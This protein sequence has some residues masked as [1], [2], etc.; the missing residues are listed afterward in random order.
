VDRQTNP[1]SN[2]PQPPSPPEEE[3]VADDKQSNNTC[4]NE[5]VSHQEGSTTIEFLAADNDLKIKEEKGEGSVSNRY[6][7]ERE[8]TADPVQQQNVFVSLWTKWRGV[9]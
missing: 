5:V 7:D 8:A 3:D 4:P 1:I 2:L 9:R 6:V